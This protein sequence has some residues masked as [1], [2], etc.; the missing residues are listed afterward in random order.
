MT[1]SDPVRPPTTRSVREQT[2]A[3]F[4][5][6]ALGNIKVWRSL[7]MEDK[8]A[9]LELSKVYASRADAVPLSFLAQHTLVPGGHDRRSERYAQDYVL[10]V[11]A[12]ARYVAGL[13]KI[14]L[15]PWRRRSSNFLNLSHLPIR[16][17]HIHP[18][19]RCDV[20]W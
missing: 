7:P 15:P 19:A 16:E 1:E 13:E 4:N 11:Y 9:Y 18:V 20:A 2:D 5:L 3:V 17:R 8:E 12:V 10:G 6:R 14:V